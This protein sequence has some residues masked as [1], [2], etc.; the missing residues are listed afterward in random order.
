MLMNTNVFGIYDGPEETLAGNRL[1]CSINVTSNYAPVRVARMRVVD[2][3]GKPVPDANV[4]FTLYN[5][6]EFY[7][8]ARRVSDS[9]GDAQL[10]TGCGDVIVWASDGKHF[11]LTQITADCDTVAPVRLCYPVDYNGEM[12]FDLT[13]PP[14]RPIVTP[15]T[16]AQKAENAARLL[17]EDNLR[18]AYMSTFANDSSIEG[19]AKRLGVERER[20]EHILK[21]SR[22]NH[23]RLVDALAQL[24]ASLRPTAI[25]LLEN[26]TEKDRRDISPE[27]LVAHVKAYKPA[28]GFSDEV[29][30]AYVL[31]PRVAY[32]AL[33]DYR[34]PLRE[35]F[36][37]ETG[38]KSFEDAGKLA[39]WISENISDGSQWNPTRLRTEPLSTLYLRSG[40]ASARKVLFVAAARSLSLPARLDMVRG[41]AQYLD[42]EGNWHD[43]L[44][45]G[46]DEKASS[47]P[48]GTLRL[49]Y[50]KQ[51]YLE[52]PSYY[53]HFTIS[54]MVDGMPRLLE[55]DEGDTS[56]SSFAEGMTL[57]AGEY[58]LTT[59]QRLADGGV[60]ARLCFF[61]VK[62]GETTDV[63]LDIRKDDTAV[64]VIG[65]L[66]AE[67]IY[68]TL[69]TK[70][71]KSILSTTG[72]GYYILG[73]L[74]NG[75]E[76][77]VHTLNDIS[78]L[79]EQLEKRG[80]KLLLLFEEGTGSGFDKS[81]Y[82]GLPAGTAFGE[83]I[84]GGI[85]KEIRESLNLDSQDLPLFVIADTFNRIVFVSQGYT[86]GLGETIVKTLD[87]IGE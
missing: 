53:F 79:K 71:E 27:V 47:T 83:D 62:E 3:D 1:G 35:F 32:E 56:Y 63:T 82:P 31:N 75:H 26:V 68:R 66:N 52:N 67:V 48:K 24:P 77:S 15:V 65:N 87:K 45:S 38:G 13:P 22:G 37:K 54:R 6:A 41:E 19:A 12:T 57:D 70:E 40:D 29:N 7:P 50:E 61:S 44:K 73:L 64:S 84:D 49:K 16:D 46:S 34:A 55:Y 81:L 80:K 60:L 43:V 72:R 76:P 59:G 39:D 4:N 2:N 78:L 20:L 33:T 21:D 69:D 30:N 36:M 42:A 74:R 17:H 18:N 51:G 85:F 8:L 25:S 86:I 10:T 9:K 5:Y 28:E 14:S 11:G 58:V 23:A